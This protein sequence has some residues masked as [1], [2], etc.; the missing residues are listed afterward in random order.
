VSERTGPAA[1][2]LY[3]EDVVVGE[4]WCSASHLVTA[5]DIAAFGVLTRDQHRL[6]TDA[7]YCRT[8]GFP[9]VIAHGLYGLALMEGL[10]T[11]LGL[12]DTT[13]IASLG[14]D[15]VRF[16][17]PIV[18]GDTLHLRFRFVSVRNS[19]QPDRGVVTEALELVN[20]DGAVVID[21]EHAGLLLRRPAFA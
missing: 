9:G 19:R 6:H 16:R 17:H 14:W 11:E 8:R 13:S 10:K 4:A 1:R 5:A 7:A 20:G 21:G 2:S 12:Y 18:A 3:L 15:K